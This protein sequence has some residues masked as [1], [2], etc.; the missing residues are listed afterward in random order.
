MTLSVES[1]VK[2]H[3]LD[4]LQGQ[5]IVHAISE[6]SASFDQI[7]AGIE[8]LTQHNVH[9]ILGGSDH[10]AAMTAVERRAI[11]LILYTDTPNTP[12]L[13]RPGKNRHTKK[14][15]CLTLKGLNKLMHQTHSNASMLQAAAY[16]LEN[17]VPQVHIVQGTTTALLQE[18]LTRTGSGTLIEKDPFLKPTFA[19]LHHVPDIMHL[20][21]ECS[22]TTTPHNVPFLKPLDKKA[23]T[24]L[25][26]T[27]LVL[28]HKDMLVGTIYW[29]FSEHSEGIP[30]IGGFAI[31]E[32]HE[33]SGY[34]RYLFQHTLQELHTRRYK[35]ALS[36]TAADNVKNLF[37]TLH[38]T[39]ASEKF[40]DLLCK[41]QKR[42]GDEAHLVRIFEF[43][44]TNPHISSGKKKTHTTGE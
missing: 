38:G 44:L 39:N 24:A 11:K 16:A 2:Q 13:M 37:T 17:E 29:D 3:Y 9:S 12:G 30:V 32:N 28:M 4:A 31:G 20:R 5:T 41:T 10:E 22:H 42:Y 8:Y 21:E 26:P 15:S 36:I 27:T 25:L 14:I 18:L 1:P 35:K 7:R 6:N 19:S 33:G 43:D 40:A 34:G 23:I